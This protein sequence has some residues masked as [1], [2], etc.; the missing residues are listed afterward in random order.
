MALLYCVHHL[1]Y[2]IIN[3]FCKCPENYV[4]KFNHKITKQCLS[5]EDKI[6]RMQK[7]LSYFYGC[8]LEI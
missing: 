6:E 7:L 4:L 2:I 8:K 5:F 1:K 3:S